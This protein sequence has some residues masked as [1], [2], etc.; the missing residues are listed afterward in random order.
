[1][2]RERVVGEWLG[3]R[4]RWEQR[5]ERDDIWSVKCNHLKG[6]REREFGER[7]EKERK[8]RSEKEKRR[9]REREYERIH[10]RKRRCPTRCPP[11]Q[12]NGRRMISVR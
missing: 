5:S 8:R 9:S 11:S 12:F 7:G 6:W 10:P 1:M 3:V 4:G 2:E